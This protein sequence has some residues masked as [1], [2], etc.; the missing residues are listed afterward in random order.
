MV[1]AFFTA[2]ARAVGALRTLIPLTAPLVS[3]GGELLLMK[4]AR[5]TEE[6][7]G[8]QRQVRSARLRD[9]R[10]EELGTGTGAEVTRVFRA[11]V[12]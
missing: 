3:S 5:V 6:L 2:T 12:G 9:T 4:G 7:A 8:A 1:R 10:V 11:T